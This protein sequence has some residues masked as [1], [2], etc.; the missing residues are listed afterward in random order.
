MAG[1]KRARCSRALGA[2]PAEKTAVCIATLLL[3]HL[4]GNVRMYGRWK[5]E[6]GEAKMRHGL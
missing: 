6:R 2:K 3:A 4:C 5:G 1:V